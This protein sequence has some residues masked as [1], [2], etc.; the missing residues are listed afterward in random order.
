MYIA[1]FPRPSAPSRSNDAA[2]RLRVRGA[3]APPRC[4]DL[5]VLGLDSGPP[6]GMDAEVALQCTFFQEN[7]CRFV[8]IRRTWPAPGIDLGFVGLEDG[9]LRRGV[10]IEKQRPEGR[11]VEIVGPDVT[12]NRSY[13]GRM[14]WARPNWPHCDQSVVRVIPDG[15]GWDV[16]ETAFPETSVE[17]VA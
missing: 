5:A 13:V 15:Q 2:H 4:G 16:R 17:E 12:G 6:D 11:L 7:P 3:I 8:D 14:G 10:M 1:L 9:V